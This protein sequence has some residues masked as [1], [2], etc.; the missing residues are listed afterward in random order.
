MSAA[1][2]TDDERGW[3]TPSKRIADLEWMAFLLLVIVGVAI[4]SALGIAAFYYIIWRN[5]GP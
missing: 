2:E 3:I 1:R 4:G 5:V